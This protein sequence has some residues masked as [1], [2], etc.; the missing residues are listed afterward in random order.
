MLTDDVILG[1]IGERLA[2]RRIDLQLTQA[3]VAEQAG[4]AKRTLERIEA[5]HSSQLSSLVRVLRVLDAMA[6]LE[7]LVPEAGPRPMDLLQRKGKRRQR[8]SGKRAG[9]TPAPAWNWGDET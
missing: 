4:I 6:G 3:A 8:A 5:G 9:K 1:E 7:T 2:A